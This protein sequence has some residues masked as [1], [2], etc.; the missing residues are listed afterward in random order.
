[1]LSTHNFVLVFLQLD[2]HIPM[3]QELVF[4]HL[5]LICIFVQKLPLHHN[6]LLLNV[7]WHLQHKCGCHKPTWFDMTWLPMLE[8][9]TWYALCFCQLCP[10]HWE[11]LQWKPLSMLQRGAMEQGHLGT[12][13]FLLDTKLEVARNFFSFHFESFTVIEYFLPIQHITPS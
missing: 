7:L 11:P 13:D 12:Q 6:H 4:D 2:L 10:H 9:W 3:L 1:M 8:A 5:G